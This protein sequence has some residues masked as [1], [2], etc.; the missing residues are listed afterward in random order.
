MDSFAGATHHEELDNNRSAIASDHTY[1]RNPESPRTLPPSSD[2]LTPLMTSLH[3][4]IS[5]IQ[6]QARLLRTQVESIERID[7]TMLEVA[8]LQVIQQMFG[9]VRR[10]L[11]NL[12]SSDNRST[13]VSS[14]RQMMAGT[15]ISDSS[16][17]DSPVEDDTNRNLNNTEQS[18]STTCGVAGISRI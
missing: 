15:R 1:P 7:R 8:Q 2:S 11:S 17:C 5:H 14:V 18:N 12:N 3:L 4:T 10:H 6:R 16:P 9:E 13:G